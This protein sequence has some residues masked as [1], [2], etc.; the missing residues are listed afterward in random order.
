M[1]K[2]SVHIILCNSFRQT[3]EPKGTCFRKG[4]GLLQYIEEES[5]D[6]GMDT[7]VTSTGCLKLCEKGPILVVYPHA[8][9]YGDVDEEKIDDILDAIEAGEPCEGL[10]YDVEEAVPA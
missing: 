1:S 6:R 3:G 2:P 10:I 4:D 7:L 9:W 5:V 8:W